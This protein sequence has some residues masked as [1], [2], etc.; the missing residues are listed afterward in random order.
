MVCTAICSL[1]FSERGVSPA[2]VS[3]VMSILPPSP[4]SIFTHRG[5]SKSPFVT[6]NCEWSIISPFPSRLRILQLMNR[7]YP[8][9]VVPSVTDFQL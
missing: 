2:A 7:L 1:S 4:A 6:H 3:H 5:T 9:I 8:F